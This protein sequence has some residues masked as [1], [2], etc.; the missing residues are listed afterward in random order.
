MAKAKVV[1][2]VEAEFNQMIGFRMSSTEEALLS[3]GADGLADYVS[4]HILYELRKYELRLRE[5]HN[6]PPP[7]WL[8]RMRHCPQCGAER[9]P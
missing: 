2:E 4:N 6:L 1:S 3:L 9:A 5:Q 7:I 8:E